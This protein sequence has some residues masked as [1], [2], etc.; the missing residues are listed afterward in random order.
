MRDKRAIFVDSALGLVFGIIMGGIL[1]LFFLL[2][3]YPTNYA[4]G[5][6]LSVVLLPIAEECCKFIPL[7]FSLFKENYILIGLFVGLGFALIE[8]FQ[9]LYI[10]YGRYGNI[11]F[12]SRIKATIL[13]ITTG[14][15]MG[16]F[17]SK[18]KGWLGLL[19]AI[20]LHSLFNFLIVF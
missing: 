7:K 10:W 12:D 17:I 6:I 14:L 16:Y 18:K 4:F 9:Y 2:F 3:K 20:L 19:L 15:L 13:H 11:P 5:L 8:N 1:Y